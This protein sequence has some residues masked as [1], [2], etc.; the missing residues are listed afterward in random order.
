MIRFIVTEA[1]ILYIIQGS[2]KLAFEDEHRVWK[3]GLSPQSWCLGTRSLSP[4]SEMQSEVQP[5]L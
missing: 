1:G 2:K 5:Q 4:Q 3:A